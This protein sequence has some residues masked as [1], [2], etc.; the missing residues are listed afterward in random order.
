MSHR[1]RE[2]EGSVEWTAPD[3]ARLKA[4]AVAVVRSRLIA[5]DLPRYCF[6]RSDLVNA[7]IEALDAPAARAERSARARK[8]HA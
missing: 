3:W 7:L 4:A 2:R 1:W 8:E 5:D 6:V